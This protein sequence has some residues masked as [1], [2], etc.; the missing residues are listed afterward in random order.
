MNG[1]GMLAMRE[2]LLPLARTDLMVGRPLSHPVFDR[3]GE[4]LLAAGQTVQ[5]EAQLQLLCT[6]GLYHN[7]RWQ[8]PGVQV[9]APPRPETASVAGAGT[10]PASHALTRVARAATDDAVGIQALKMIP[11]GGTREFSVRLLGV[12]PDNTILVSAPTEEGKLIFVK[13][14]QTFRLQG[15]FGEAVLIFTS[16]IVKVQFAPFPYLHLSWP[17]PSRIQRKHVRTA[18]RA[19][20]RLPCVVYIEH[21]SATSSVHGFVLDVSTGGAEIAVPYEAPDLKDKV[22]LAFRIIVAGRSTL[23]EHYGQI[24]RRKP[25]ERTDGVHYGIQFAELPAELELVLHAYILELLVA[26]LECPLRI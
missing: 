2:E 10:E 5:S 9:A 4:L 6:R 16:S 1:A 15:L 20:C 13:E 8:T 26:Q 21:A 23:V 17:D 19:H 25:D 22:R 11:E 7:P 12:N 24:V 14:G 18:R 3:R